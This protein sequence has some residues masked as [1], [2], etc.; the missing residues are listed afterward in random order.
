[1]GTMESSANRKSAAAPERT[2]I[3]LLVLLAAIVAFLP[4]LQN[5]FVNWDDD[6]NLLENPNFRGLG[7]KE[8]RWMFSTFYMSNYRPLTWV[9][10][11]ADY[12]LWGMIPSGYHLTSLLLHGANALLLYFITLRL[13]TIAFTAPSAPERLALKMGAAFAALMFGVHPLRVEAVAWA[14]ARNDVLSGFFLLWSVLCYLRYAAASEVPRAQSRWMVLSVMLYAFS[15][16][17]KAMGIMFPIV[18]MTLDVYPL[19]RLSGGPGSWFGPSARRVWWEKLPYLV[20]GLVAALLAVIAKVEQGAVRT[21]DLYGWA[22]RIAQSFY[23]LAFYLWKTVLPVSL[24]PLYELPVHINPWDWHFILS[25]AAVLALSVVCFVLRRRWPAG[26]AAWVCYVV[27]LAPVLGIAQSGPQSVADR[28]SYL[29]CMGFAMLLGTGLI[30]RGPFR[31]KEYSWTRTFVVGLP[32]AI[33]LSLGILTWKQARIWHDSETLWRN[34]LVAQESKLAHNNLGNVLA[35]KGLF[36]EAAYH[37]RGAIRIDAAYAPAYNNLGL[38]FARLGDL[39]RA[40]ENYRQ[41]LRI[42]PIYTDAHTNLANVLAS[43]GELEQAEHHYRQALRL[44]PN[45]MKA[46]NNLGLILAGRGELEEATRH[47]LMAL[48]SNPL[49]RDAHL[50]HFNLANALTALGQMDQ[51]LKHFRAAVKIQP[52][53]AEAHHGLGR[54]MAELGKLDEAIGHFEQA[55]RINP[56][57][58]EARESLNRALELKKVR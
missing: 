2:L 34:A 27:I 23:G 38:I 24:S 58:Q 13:F 32:I 48:E 54:V 5:G 37:Y 29:P 30:H 55:I 12:L 42:N 43:R 22:P 57:L 20:L 11:G 16:L 35:D 19:R 53:F 31:L 17:S 18:L 1:M 7:W 26:L 41:A 39:D 50:I 14:S 47:Y 56:D 46:H 25:T 4:I 44:N 49:K 36:Q 28:Y 10:L 51:A 21:L 6:K 45:D 9:S 40:V 15:L 33:L 8:I 52:Y 3:P